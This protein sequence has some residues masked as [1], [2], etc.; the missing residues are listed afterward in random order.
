VNLRV[1]DLMGRLI[2]TLVDEEESEGEHETE[3]N[4]R[5]VNGSVAA[6]GVYFYRLQSGSF[7][8]AEKMILLR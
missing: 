1:F 5:T 2:A 8:G 7:Q 4:G 3:W 6:S